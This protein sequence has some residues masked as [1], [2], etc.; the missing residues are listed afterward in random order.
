MEARDT[1]PFDALAAKVSELGQMCA[2]LSQENAEL[3][4]QVSRLSAGTS[5]AAAPAAAP[6]RAARS[7][8]VGG[9]TRPV[10]GTIS[11][12]MVGKAMGAAAVGAVGAAALVDLGAQP[13]AATNGNAITAGNITTAESGTTLKY[14]SASNLAGVVFLAND[15]GFGN[16]AASFPAALGG[17]AG[18]HVAN[19]I[20]GYTEVNGGNAIVGVAAGGANSVGVTG[21][22]GPGTAIQGISGAGTG[23]RGSG[24]TGVAAVGSTVAVNANGPTAVLANG[25]GAAG[26]GVTATN[27]SATNAAVKAANSGTGNGIHATSSGGRGGVF[28]GA[29]AQIQ[30]T[31][32]SRSTHPTSGRRG[33]LYADKTGR[34]WFCK[35]SGTHATWHQI[36]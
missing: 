17:W 34:L 23:V 12:R 2:R 16:G 11:R 26:Q 32:G 25:T 19:G 27:N 20:Y 3:R 6:G 28:G 8:P 14:D 29:P 18:G 30:L 24:S 33:D 10:A 21:T 36:A 31:P 22:N 9:P 7:F 5:P 35:K 15:T 4:D 1:S 13:A